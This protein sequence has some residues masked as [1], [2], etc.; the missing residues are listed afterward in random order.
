MDP[1]IIPRR[2]GKIEKSVLMLREAIQPIPKYWKEIP[3][4]P[5]SIL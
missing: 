2:K 3:S 5:G 4:Q 1:S